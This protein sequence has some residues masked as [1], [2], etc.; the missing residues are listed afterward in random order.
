MNAK[1]Y[2]CSLK[3]GG[4]QTMYAFSMPRRGAWIGVVAAAAIITGGP[5]LGVEASGSGQPGWK[6]LKLPYK[7]PTRFRFVEPRM[8]RVAADMSVAFYYRALDPRTEPARRLIWRWRV[9]RSIP[10]TDQASR[11]GDDR[12]IAVHLWFARRDRRLLGQLRA[13]RSLPRLGH[14][15]TYVWGGKRPRGAVVANPYYKKGAIIILRNGRATVGRW[16]RESRDIV[17]DFERAFGFTPN[18]KTLRYMAV[19]GDTD[20]TGTISVARIADI[21]MSGRRAP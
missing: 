20:D 19:S 10:A 3:V 12:P 1:S 14:M 5:A 6:L 11:G 13:L 15:I 8:L 21:R 17:A 2:P 4:G 18:L 16:Y 9:D 7:K